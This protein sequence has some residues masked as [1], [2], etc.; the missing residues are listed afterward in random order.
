MK[1]AIISL[2][3]AFGMFCAIPLPKYWDETCAKHVMPWLPVVGAAIGAIW[4]I[5]AQLLGLLR[6]RAPDMLLAGALMLVP[7]FASGFIHLDGYMD[8]SDA[9][10]SRRTREE[11]LRILKDSHTGAFAVIMVVILFV[12]QFAAVY[13]VFTSGGRFVLLL[14]IP[15]MSRCCSALSI[16]CLKPL[17]REGYAYM[18]RPAN[19]A[20]HRAFAI[21]AAVSVIAVAWLLAGAPGL[22]VLGAVVSGYAAAMA[23]AYVSFRGVSGDLA[24]FAMVLSELAGLIVLAVV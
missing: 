14:V 17:K 13:S 24:G 10:M 19:A 20:P 9:I 16:L 12:M 23:R 4:Y 5:A 21:T 6:P 3:M 15:V 7:F 18:F 8:T 2:Y 1:K 22:I 11:K